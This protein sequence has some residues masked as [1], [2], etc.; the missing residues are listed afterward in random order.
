MSESQ[1]LEDEKEQDPEKGEMIAGETEASASAYDNPD[2]Q[3]DDWPEADGQWDEDKDE[4]DDDEDDGGKDEED[5]G[6]KDEE[7]EDDEDEVRIIERDERNSADVNRKQKIG[8][9]LDQK[10][11]GT[12]V[13]EE[14]T[15][16]K[17]TVPKDQIYKV[18]RREDIL[19]QSK[20]DPSKF[21]CIVCLAQGGGLVKHF[22][23][24]NRGSNV[25]QHWEKHETATV[26]MSKPFYIMKEVDLSILK[27][28][29]GVKLQYEPLRQ[30]K[31]MK[32]FAKN[33]LSPQE[34]FDRAAV[35]YQLEYGLSKE[36][37]RGPGFVRMIEA[38][39][40]LNTT[41]RPYVP[42][43]LQN[44]LT[45]ESFEKLTMFAKLYLNGKDLENKPLDPELRT[46]GYSLVHDAWDWS[47]SHHL[48]GV[49]IQ[50]IQV[51]P[52]SLSFHKVP[53]A[54]R[55]Y[56]AEQ[57]SAKARKGSK[58]M[59]G[60]MAS[61]DMVKTV[62]ERHGI[63]LANVISATGDGAASATNLSAEIEEKSELRLFSGCGVLGTRENR[64]LVHQIGLAPKYAFGLATRGKDSEIPDKVDEAVLVIIKTIRTIVNVCSQA[65]A[66]QE[67][68]I[69]NKKV[70]VSLTA[71]HAD[72]EVR[73]LSTF[74]MISAFAK[75][76]DT[77][78]ACAESPKS[79]LKQF[80]GF[81]VKY[82]KKE[83]IHLYA[84]VKPLEMLTTVLE[85]SNKPISM[86][87]LPVVAVLLRAYGVKFLDGLMNKSQIRDM[88][89]QELA[90]QTFEVEQQ[91]FSEGPNWDSPPSSKYESIKY[92]NLTPSAQK[93]YL[94]LRKH[95]KYRLLEY[96]QLLNGFEVLA[97][98]VD[99]MTHA[100]A[101]PV[102][103]SKKTT[104][105]VDIARILGNM[106]DGNAILSR[107]EEKKQAASFDD[108]WGPGISDQ[109]GLD[110]TIEAELNE[111]KRE[112]TN[113]NKDK[114]KTL[115]SVV[116]RIQDYNP[117]EFWTKEIRS[118]M[119]RLF[120][121]NL[122]SLSVATSS[123]MQESVFSSAGDTLDQRR[124]R[125][126]D[127]PNELEETICARVILAKARRENEADRKATREYFREQLVER[128]TDDKEP[129]SKTSKARTTERGIDEMFS[130]RQK[131]ADG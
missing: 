32:T 49:C 94:C 128:V 48:L 84:V 29:E 10:D 8:L 87:S 18:S 71:M 45:V 43:Y 108:E 25:R 113:L 15:T 14:L 130:K 122:H 58:T 46:V 3:G 119:P 36:A 110:I 22:F 53:L 68:V 40:R 123:I 88:D 97:M 131:M 82:T 33:G 99:P 121:A 27:G 65:K 23:K 57:P 34:A 61:L 35:D 103:K 125:L 112:T 78:Q 26:T 81:F 76:Y 129:P 59:F 62:M 80:K 101:E 79:S 64:C 66:K 89:N 17:V 77:L 100:F 69:A 56:E 105:D 12:K 98:Y 73:W 111:L 90:S 114:S 118:R 115:V 75:N 60:A 2:F 37:I 19:F 44:K 107:H 50:F 86:F 6:A 127:N 104:V 72:M 52:D 54:F 126:L 74:H 124:R 67:L 109:G 95:L 24:E 92:A 91:F 5:D 55:Q 106:E 70:Q 11:I 117:L 1:V 42:R 21:L 28:F 63:P 38:A 4:V 39:R 16:K 102:L 9:K 83:I 13:L 41:N 47:A 7:D 30:E 96:R 31:T 93:L 85:S 116:R 120:Q 20:D 51:E